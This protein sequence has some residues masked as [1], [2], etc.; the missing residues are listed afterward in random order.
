MRDEILNE[1]LFFGV[2]HARSA[3]AEW[4]EVFNTARPH[5]S[6]N[7]QTQA[8]FAEVLT[9]TGSGA[10]LDAGFTSPPVAQ[11]APYGVTETAEALIAAG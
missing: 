3:F 4:R 11:S 8:A 1:S 2:E 10:S 6:L 5:S 7:Y 9:G